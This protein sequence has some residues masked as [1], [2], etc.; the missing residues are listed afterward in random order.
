MPTRRFS[1]LASA[2]VAL[3]LALSLLA[4]HFQPTEV[5]ASSYFG[6][7]SRIVSL[8]VTPESPPSLYALVRTNRPWEGSGRP[9][10]NVFRSRDGGRSWAEAS[11]GGMERVIDAS[12]LA[13]D[14]RQPHLLYLAAQLEPE[15][16]HRVLRS[17]DGGAWEVLSEP[18]AGLG[19][20]AVDLR[21][22]SVLYAGARRDGL[23]GV[24]LRSVDGGR[25]WQ[26]FDTA[27]PNPAL[28]PSP[29]ILR[30]PVQRILVDSVDPEVLYAITVWS[31]RY[32]SAQLLRGDR[33]GN[34]VEV[35]VPAPS[36]GVMGV[37]GIAFDPGT[38]SLYLGSGFWGGGGSVEPAARKLWRSDNPREA[39]P[40]RVAWREVSSFD[41][42]QAGWQ[43][44]VPSADPLAVDAGGGSTIYLQTH[45]ADT[46]LWRSRDGG[47]SWDPVVMPQPLFAAPGTDPA[48]RWTS[49]D[50]GHM[51]SG[52]WLA[53]L[54]GHGDTA[55]LGY[56]RSGVIADPMAGGQTVQYFQRLVLEW[57][58][59]N[60]PEYRIQRRLLGDIIFPGAD[61][62]VDPRDASRRPRGEVH[63]FPAGPGIGL[64]HYVSDY[65]PDGTAIYFK[66]YFDSHG[67]VD[68]FGFPKEE[69]KLRDGRWTQR[70]QAAV[71]EYHPQHDVPGF[72]PGADI[73]WRSF[74]VQL[75]LLGDRYIEANRLPYR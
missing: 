71:F 10:W 74:R 63:Y 49:L 47:R 20:L 72:L 54:K 40:A 26:P 25:S 68:A 43:G 44:F 3:A 57:H 52:E 5:G 19:A 58:P 2:G 56:P 64:G 75:E 46:G 61:P 45:A 69:P 16:G 12:S 60:P 70:F 36:G 24:F 34:W 13:V 38:N 27:V 51:V 22:S 11:P 23:Y 15:A 33:Q 37:A 9:L 14:Y 50:T 59:E 67:G 18:V 6:Y 8:V 66:E 4:A 48:L 28:W 62:P 41:L 31:Y 21:D 39:D 7:N 1:I 29:G 73:P 53:F 65:A 17:A 42:G 55:N 35:P 30:Y 32:Y